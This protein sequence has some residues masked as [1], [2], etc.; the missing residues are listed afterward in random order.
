MDLLFL[1]TTASIPDLHDDCPSFLINEKFLFD[2]GW[3]AV[4]GLRGAGCD[5]SKLRYVLFTHLHHDHYLGLA[6]LLFYLIHNRA[7]HPEEKI[8]ALNELTIVGPDEDLS[9]VLRLTYA[10]LQLDRFY[11]DLPRP[12]AMPIKAGDSFQLDGVRFATAASLHPV[13]C[14]SYKIDDGQARLGVTGD[15][16]Y[17][18]GA[19]DYFRGCGALIHDSTLALQENLEPPA[20]RKN[21]H[22]TL[23]EAVQTAEEAGVPTLFPMHMALDVC[24]ASAEAIQSRTQVQIIAARRGERYTLR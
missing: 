11:P 4:D 8:P 14:I 2:C 22:S 1:G 19:A 13:Q 10:F 20:T 18:P 16:A 5:L 23:A 15:T 24:R 21:G 12:K 3:N 17:Q 9:R 7:I 6:G